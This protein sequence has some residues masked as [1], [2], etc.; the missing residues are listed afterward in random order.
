VPGPRPLAGQ[1]TAEVLAEVSTATTPSLARPATDAQMDAQ[2]YA[3]G[4]LRVLDF[5]RAF[6]GPFACMVIASMGADVIKV[7]APGVANMGG[8]PQLG[9]QAGKR[10]IAV[11][12]KRPE[13][14]RI[15]EELIARSDVVHHNMTKGV[16]ERLGIDQETLRAIKPD[17]VSCNTFMYGPT[18]PLADLGGLDP[19][20]QAAAGL[21]YEAGPVAEGNRPLWYRFGHGDT[22]NALASIVGTLMAVYNRKRTGKGQAVWTSL[23]HGTA[24]WGSGAH[25]V[26]DEL[27]ELAKF[28]KA[29]TGLDALY[30][31]YETADGWLQIAAVRPEHWPALCQAI[32]NATLADDPRFTSMESRRSNR[33][34][35]EAELDPVMR[36]RT[37]LQWRRSFDAAGVPSEIS[38]PTIDGD[39]LLF[40][41]EMVDLGLVV[42]YEHPVH[43]SLRQVGQLVTF[44]DTPGRVERP[45]ALPGEHTVE[46]M[47][48][49]GYDDETIALYAKDGIIAFPEG[50]LDEG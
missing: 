40:D 14:R 34:A 2:T 24:L 23:L 22:A 47:R 31:L 4:D 12:G 41:E 13:G 36:T 45:P 3:L 37:A 15:I 50:A 8:G 32:G 1:H 43:G 49:L 30:R 16:A 21:E 7:E 6:A 10:A 25:R 18:G 5:G 33:A 29:Q 9:C 38:M 42:N 17:I 27:V 35:L 19:L 11:D 48:W 46:I 20:S 39:T 44:A 28:D 26:G